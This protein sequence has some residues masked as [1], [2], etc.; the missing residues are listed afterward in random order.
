MEGSCTRWL[1]APEKACPQSQTRM[2]RPES[3]TAIFRTAG[4][5]Y[6]VDSFIERAGSAVVCG[7]LMVPDV[8]TLEAYHPPDDNHRQ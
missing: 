5:P 1:Q 7:G 8:L 6:S 4:H 2:K 3:D